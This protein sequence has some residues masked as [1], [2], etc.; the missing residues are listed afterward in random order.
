MFDFANMFFYY[1][2]I[3]K[4]SIKTNEVH[5]LNHIFGV[6]SHEVVVNPILHYLN[7]FLKN[8]LLELFLKSNYDFTN[9]SSFLTWKVDMVT[10]VKL[11]KI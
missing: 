11:Q 1:H 5:E 3:I 4:K 7:T 2:I 6:L 9:H 10:L 8:I